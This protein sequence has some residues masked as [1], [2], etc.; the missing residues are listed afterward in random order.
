MRKILSSPNGFAGAVLL[1]IV[2]AAALLGPWIAPYDPQLFH[3]QNRLEGP[4]LAHWL[5]TDQYGRDLLSRILNG[6]PSTV[7]FG[8]GATALGVCAGSTIGVIAG[9]AGGRTD[10]I[11]MRLLDGM[12]AMPELLFTL[13]IVTFLG[14]GMLQALLAVGVAFTPGMA[15]IARSAVLSVRTREYVLAARARGE[16]RAWIVLREV[17]PNAIGPIIV[18]ATIRVS[19]AI[20]IGATLGFLGL[21]AQPPSTEWGLMVSEARQFMFRSPWGVIIPGIAIAMTAM[22]FNLFGDALRDAFD[23]KRSH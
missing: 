16:S 4:S 13:L 12:L 10:S 3:A 9:V 14:G 19:F 8:I 11:I 15:R 21:G 18:E 17:M 20:M 22:G 7:L 23:P 2:L 6:A 1:T 5:G